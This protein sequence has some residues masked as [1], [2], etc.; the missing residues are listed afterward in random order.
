MEKMNARMMAMGKLPIGSLFS[1][2]AQQEEWFR[3]YRVCFTPPL[4]SPLGSA[5][6]FLVAG[7]L[8]A[9]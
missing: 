4:H 6:P 3:V 2:W 9:L 1:L 5:E 8:P 7:I